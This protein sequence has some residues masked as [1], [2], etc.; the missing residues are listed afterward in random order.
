MVVVALISFY[1]ISLR[2]NELPDDQLAR[3]MENL[4]TLTLF[5]VSCPLAILFGG[6]TGWLVEIVRR[7]V[8][9]RF[10]STS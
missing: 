3:G 8:E 10:S 6:V 5:I 9:T 2:P 1:R 4:C 7:A